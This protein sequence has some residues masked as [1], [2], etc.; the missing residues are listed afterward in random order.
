MTAN[1]GGQLL[2]AGI[3]IGVKIPEP[4]V[5]PQ[6]FPVLNPVLT[7]LRLIALRELAFHCRGH[8]Q[9]KG[10]HEGQDCDFNVA[11]RAKEKL[12]G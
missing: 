12:K 10:S 7:E 5:G 9:E 4:V 8:R 2:S 11:H 3:E 6:E 1:K